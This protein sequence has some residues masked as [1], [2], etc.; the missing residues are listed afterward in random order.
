MLIMNYKKSKGY[1]ER[2]LGLSKEGRNK[3]K[4][5]SKDSGENSKKERAKESAALARRRKN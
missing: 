2:A 5:I 4:P 3:I 1:Y